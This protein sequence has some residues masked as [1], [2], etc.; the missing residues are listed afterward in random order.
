MAVLSHSHCGPRARRGQSLWGGPAPLP[1]P[2]R[3]PGAGT[4]VRP[5]RR[6]QLTAPLTFHYAD[7]GSPSATAEGIKNLPGCGVRLRGRGGGLEAMTVQAGRGRAEGRW[8]TPPAPRVRQALGSG[9]QR[10]AE[11][12][13]GG[14]GAALV[15]AWTGPVGG[16]AGPPRSLRP[17][18]PSP[19]VPWG[20]E[21]GGGWSAPGDKTQLWGR[22]VLAPHR[23]PT[24]VPECS[25]HSHGF[26][27]RPVIA[28]NYSIRIRRGADPQHSSAPPR[29]TLGAP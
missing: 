27:T 24:H 26:V 5:I 28:G 19:W 12:P 4:E 17:S 7:I 23:T 29:K 3:L 25:P 11:P 9:G 10:T 2:G 14:G 13:P 15:L 21:A 20:R 8:V 1:G 6:Q 16:T 22:E 18:C